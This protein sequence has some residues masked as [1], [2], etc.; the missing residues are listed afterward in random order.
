MGTLRN[1]SEILEG[2]SVLEYSKSK[3]FQN[4]SENPSKFG[5]IENPSKIS[6]SFQ[7]SIFCGFQRCENPS[8]NPSSRVCVRVRTRIYMEKYIPVGYIYFSNVNRFGRIEL[9]QNLAAKNCDASPL[10]PSGRLAAILPQK[11]YGSK[12]YALNAFNGCRKTA[13]NA[14][15]SDNTIPY[16]SK[17]AISAL[18]CVLSDFGFLNLKK[19]ES[20]FSNRKSLGPH[21]RDLRL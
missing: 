4:P 2:F 12:C 11:G 5:I 15:D 3:S 7:T 17:R 21:W 18:K 14:C 19:K 1:R 10:P 20:I 9:F 16:K 6:K 13:L 8:K